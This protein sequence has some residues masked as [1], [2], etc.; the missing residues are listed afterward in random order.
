M[1]ICACIDWVKASVQSA[2]FL[3]RKHVVWCF[4][5]IGQRRYR[6][7]WCPH[8]W[9][10]SDLCIDWECFGIRWRILCR[11]NVCY[12]SSGT[13]INIGKRGVICCCTACWLIFSVTLCCL[14]YIYS[15]CLVKVTVSLHRFRL[16]W[17]SLLWK[18]WTEWKKDKSISQICEER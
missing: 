4:G 6:T 10:R 7:L 5:R 2:H 17:Q 12:W 16:F 14:F 8:Q 11:I 13:L 18:V 15:D 1:Y 9:S 3:G